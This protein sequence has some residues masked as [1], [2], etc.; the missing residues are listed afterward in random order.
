MPKAHVSWVR[1]SGS[2]MFTGSLFLKFRRPVNGCRNRTVHPPTQ[3]Y[4]TALES[5]NYD[6]RNLLD[7]TSTQKVLA[8]A[9]SAD[10]LA[11][12][13]DCRHSR[14]LRS[15]RAMRFNLKCEGNC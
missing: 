7:V 15:A 9:R 12:I 14:V 1:T 10:I 2:R 4:S 6:M 8:Q 13:K 11:R 3:S 5:Y